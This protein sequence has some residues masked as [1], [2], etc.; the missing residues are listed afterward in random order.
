[1][2]G[3]ATPEHRKGVA[4]KDGATAKRYGQYAADG[5]RDG[6]CIPWV[7]QRRRRK[8]RSTTL[9][10]HYGQRR[11]WMLV[12]VRQPAPWTGAA[13]TALLAAAAAAVRRGQPAIAA[14]SSRQSSSRQRFWR[15]WRFER[16]RRIQR[17]RWSRR[18]RRRSRRWRSPVA[19]NTTPQLIAN[20]F[21]EDSA[22]CSC[23]P[24]SY[25]HRHLF[26]PLL[27]LLFALACRRL[28]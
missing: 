1:M 20:I 4:Y 26:L 16:R 12:P 23:H 14:M 27:A 8:L 2:P 25:I 17:R 18:W 3:S 28:P 10:R 22:R 19:G 7:R 11:A 13:A 9:S 6:C 5:G 15:R 24:G 21:R